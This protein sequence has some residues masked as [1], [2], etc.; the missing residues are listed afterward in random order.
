M[1]RIITVLMAALL[2]LAGLTACGG[3][4]SGGD[5]ETNAS[6]DAGKTK[7]ITTIF[8][9]YDWTR[10]IAGGNDSNTEISMLID[11]GVDLHSFQPSAEDIMKI[12]ECDVFIYVG[13]ESDEWV[14]D[15][16]AAAANKDMR[17][18][19]LLDILGDKAKE[20]ETVEGMQ[21][22]EHEHEEGEGAHEEGENTHDEGEAM[23]DE[24]G[25]AHE[26]GEDCHE[27]DEHIWL[28]LQ[29]ASELVDAIAS[30]LTQADESGA[31]T[32]EAN[33]AAYK[34]KLAALD[35]EYKAA[36]GEGSVK[37]L[38]FGD[39]FPFR[40]MT[41][42]YGLDYYAT[43]AGCSAE[44]EASF[45]TIAF[46]AGKVD[47][48]GLKNIMTIEGRAHSIAES[49]KDNTKEKNQNILTL[50]S[51]QSVTADDAANGVTYLGIMEDNLE[52]LRAALE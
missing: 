42:D 1:K 29:N 19:K 31:A 3:G 20:E 7:I 16:L 46:L 23:H 26:E 6:E 43:F 4:N 18:V 17:V 40:Y 47:E 36:A 51:M 25:D 13:G 50:N 9:V 52:V 32:Y 34:D 27:Y 5:K 39:R 15:A 12:S 10:S 44:T 22:D 35:A 49:I 33:A 41:D 2:I 14:E 45:E 11:S 8:P 28:S 21:P 37:T 30:A 24:D 48:L 38:L